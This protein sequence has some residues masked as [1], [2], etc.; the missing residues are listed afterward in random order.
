M[1]LATDTKIETI[2]PL[3]ETL[4]ETNLGTVTLIK[5]PRRTRLTGPNLHPL[6]AQNRHP[7]MLKTGKAELLTKMTIIALE[8][9]A[10]AP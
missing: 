1:I 8:Q 5:V 10:P 3:I 4:T 6:T 2:R 9:T 7:I